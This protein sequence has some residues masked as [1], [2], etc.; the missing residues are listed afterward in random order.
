M[1]QLLALPVVMGIGNMSDKAT[2]ARLSVADYVSI[3]WAFSRTRHQH[4]HI[5]T[6][7][8]LLRFHCSYHQQVTLQGPFI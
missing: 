4:P 5:T 2:P 7:V 3:L 8:F 6:L 1:A